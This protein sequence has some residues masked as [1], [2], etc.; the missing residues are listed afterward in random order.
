MPEAGTNSNIKVVIGDEGTYIK[1]DDNG[2]DDFEQGRWVNRKLFYVT[3]VC[4]RSGNIIDYTQHSNCLK[5]T[6]AV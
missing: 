4:K 1:L 6:A 2:R 3:V 5:K